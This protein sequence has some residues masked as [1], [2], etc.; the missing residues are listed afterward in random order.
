MSFR[1]PLALFIVVLWS[2]PAVADI[3][4]WF[5]PLVEDGGAL[6]AKKATQ[7]REIRTSRTPAANP[8]AGGGAKKGTPSGKAKEGQFAGTVVLYVT[9]WCPHCK[10]AKSYL[11]R[12]G[13]PY[14]AYDIE[15]DSAARERHQQLGGGGVP[16][17]LVGS[18]KMSGFSP[19]A[20]EYYLNNSR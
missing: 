1:M 8:A 15:K 10:S 13:I 14:V 16:L 3:Y 17:I 9:S 19:Q 7:Y 6:S 11:D 20:L 18:R 2:S 4:Q 5:Y 12:R